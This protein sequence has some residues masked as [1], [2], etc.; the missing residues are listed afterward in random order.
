MRY[1]ICDLGVYIY[2]YVFCWYYFR[3]VQFLSNVI[4]VCATCRYE[5]WRTCF[6]VSRRLFLW[7]QLKERSSPGGDLPRRLGR[8]YYF[9][10]RAAT[11]TLVSVLPQPRR[12]ISILLLSDDPR[13][14]P[15]R[16]FRSFYRADSVV[17][18]N[19]KKKTCIQLH[20]GN[21]NAVVGKKAVSHF[22]HAFLLFWYSQLN[23][24]K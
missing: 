7:M 3:V 1:N 18:L 14:S 17:S 20:P 24:V 10:L 12:R 13:Y 6:S 5:L 11:E 15:L 4:I 22:R 19:E 8:L 21:H 9:P 16:F 2:I 23:G